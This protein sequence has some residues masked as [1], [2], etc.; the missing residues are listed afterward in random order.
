VAWVDTRVLASRVPLTRR[1]YPQQIPVQLIEKQVEEEEEE[2]EEER[3]TIV[4][5]VHRRE[6]L[7]GIIHDYY[8]FDTPAA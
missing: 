7:G 5:S 8:R 2:E 4:G 6:V 3:L 1:Q